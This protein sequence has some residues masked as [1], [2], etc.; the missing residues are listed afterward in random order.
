VQMAQAIRTI[1]V[2]RGLDVRRFSLLAFGGAGPLFA[3][4]LAAGLD[5]AEVLV[6]RHPGVFCAEGLL[7]SD[8]RHVVQTVHRRALT[9]LDCGEL[10]AKAG[11]LK[12]QLEVALTADGIEPAARRYRLSGDLR[13][14]GQ[15]HELELPLPLPGEREWWESASIAG[16][17]H[18]AHRTAYGH[19]EAEAPIELVNLRLTGL[20]RIDRPTAEP[21]QAAAPYEPAALGQH[22]VYLDRRTGLIPCR[23]YDRADFAPGAQVRGPALIHQLDTTVLVMPGHAAETLAGG[24]LAITAVNGKAS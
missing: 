16:R 23:H 6:P 7:M 1:S 14:L 9:D 21:E 15:F 24:V 19:A 18:D 2:E 13:Y 3:P 5:M 10:A 11:S 8:I 20:G 12:D 4:Y 17:F 22:P